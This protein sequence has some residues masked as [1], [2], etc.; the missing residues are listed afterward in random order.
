MPSL[1]DYLGMGLAHLQSGRLAD[2][3]QTFRAILN[4]QPL[5]PAAMLYLGIVVSSMGRHGEAVDWMTRACYLNPHP[6]FFLNLAQAYRQAGQ[7]REAMTT[8][9]RALQLDP[10]LPDAHEAYASLLL[11]EKRPA[12]AVARLREALR[13]DPS[14]ASTHNL[15]G[16]ALCEMHK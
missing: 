9:E 3:E 8:Y 16:S 13:L 7:T 12:D 14:R 10:T 1:D 5:H 2:A 11:K 6:G 4:Q 15:L